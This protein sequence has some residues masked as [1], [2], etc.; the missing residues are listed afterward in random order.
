MSFLRKNAVVTAYHTNLQRLADGSAGVTR[1]TMEYIAKAMLSMVA[2]VETF[3]TPVAQTSI[4]AD[5]G[6]YGDS[7]CMA[8][9]AAWLGRYAYLLDTPEQLR[10]C[11]S[12]A[13]Q[14]SPVYE[15]TVPREFPK[16]QVPTA[17]YRFAE[18]IL[19]AVYEAASEG[20]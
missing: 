4:V 10:I 14:G 9:R 3:A 2:D 17:E 5:D 12:E 16:D 8:F 11:W 6:K 13:G 7:L 1:L 18:F 15:F 20:L 19:Q